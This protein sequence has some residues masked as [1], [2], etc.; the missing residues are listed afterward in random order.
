MIHV[1]NLSVVI[2]VLYVISQWIS[3]CCIKV[4]IS[5]SDQVMSVKGILFFIMS[6]RS[7]V[8]HNLQV[9]SI[10]GSIL[11]GSTPCCNDQ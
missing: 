11:I 4:F 3:G 2:W 5:L 8:L 1:F 9:G 6:I 7:V 10:S